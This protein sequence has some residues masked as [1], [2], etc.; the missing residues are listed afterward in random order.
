[1]H[2][3][4]LIDKLKLY[5]SRFPEDEQAVEDFLVF[6]EK[7][8]N[9]FERTLLEGHITGSCLLLSPD[10]QKVLLT[11][12][13]KLNMWIQ[14]GGHSDGNPD[15]LDVALREAQEESGIEGVKPID[16]QIFSIDI[17]MIPAR[18]NEPEHYHYDVTYLLQAEHENYQVSEESHDLKWLPI[19]E[20][21]NMELESSLKRM[22]SRLHKQSN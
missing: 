18:K 15:S 1:M 17:H 16:E 3:N 8:E 6:V 20:L 2:R 7:H 12:H 4:A 14:L 9:C 21:V 19:N 11:H 13:K 10:K 5:K 22:I